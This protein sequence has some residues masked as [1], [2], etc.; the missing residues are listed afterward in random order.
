MIGG[1][2]SERGSHGISMR[3]THFSLD[4]SPKGKKVEGVGLR[5]VA[6]ESWLSIRRR[7][8]SRNVVEG[9]STP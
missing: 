1:G 6:L 2:L 7:I 5:Y 9:V 4:D 3:S 8:G